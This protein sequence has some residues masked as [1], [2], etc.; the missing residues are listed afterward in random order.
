MIREPKT[1]PKDGFSDWMGRRQ[2]G[3]DTITPGL[4]ERFMATVPGLQGHALDAALPPCIHW[5]LAPLVEPAERLG[6]DGHPA[7]GLYLPAIP[8]PRRMWAG[9]DLEFHDDLK[10]GDAVTRRSTIESVERKQGKS[11]DLG[12]VTLR[13]DLSTSRGLAVVERQT[14]VYRDPAGDGSFS[15]AR[16]GGKPAPDGVRIATDPV[17]LFRYSA[18]TFN[19]HRI[20]YDHPY[21][22]GVEGY[23][24]LVVHGPLIATLLANLARDRLGRLRRFSFRGRAPAICGEVLV[25]RCQGRDSGADLDAHSAADGRLIMTAEAA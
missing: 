6:H 19:G 7:L 12:F 10:T 8:L 13:H 16:S 21:A 17:L 2:T 15:S 23:R 3:E 20:H 4:V 1:W 24:G 5:C 25:L 11:G 18:L 9:S 22:T 14:L